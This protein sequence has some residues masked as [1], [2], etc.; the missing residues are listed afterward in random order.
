[1]KINYQ[2]LVWGILCISVWACQSTG[3]KTLEST[4][5]LS[6]EQKAT[7]TDEIMQLTSDWA[8]A[9]I[10][11]NADKSIRLWDDSPDLMFAEN[12]MFFPGRDSIYAYLK[13]FYTTT[14]SMNVEW[15]QRVVVPLAP[16]AAVMSGKFHFKATFESGDV[17]ESTSMF[18][19]VFKKKNGRW[20]I[21]HGHESFNT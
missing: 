10:Q 4:S 12:G 2:L 6:L 3:K 20:V 13:E 19:G 18:T 14:T 1:M 7:I 5:A 21:I 9:N 11:M 8:T 16:D 15:L 17:Y